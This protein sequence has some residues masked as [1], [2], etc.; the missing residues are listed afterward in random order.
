MHKRIYTLIVLLLCL[1]ATAGA[2]D[3]RLTAGF[4]VQGR[5]GK[6]GVPAVYPTSYAV[7]KTVTKARSVME[8]LQK[9]VDAD[10]YPGGPN[11]DE[12][13]LKDNVR[14]RN[15]K[16]NGT[17]SVR[18]Y[19]GQSVLVYVNEQAFAV[20][21]IK[22]GKTEYAE[23]VEFKM[24]G[25]H[26]LDNV[27]VEG[28]RKHD[29]IPFDTD[30]ADDD[31]VNMS[32]HISFELPEG[33]TGKNT[34]VMVQPVA[35]DCQTEDTADYVTPLVYEGVRYHRLQSR[36]MDFGYSVNEPEGIARGF[37]P[38]RPLR[39]G[40][41]F[42]VDTTLIYRKKDI[43]RDY[44]ICCDILVEDYTHRYMHLSTAGSCNKRKMFKFLSLDGVAA[45]L[46]LEEYRIEAEETMRA[47]P[48]DLKL[49]FVVGKAEL[50]ADSLNDV[51]LGMLVKEMKDYGDQLMRVEIEAYASPDGGYEKNLSLARERGRAA[52]NLVMRGLGKADVTKGLRT[53]VRTWEDV[54]GELS[55]AGKKEF[56]DSVRAIIGT[57][58]RQPDA[59]LRK[60]SFYAT[61]IEPVL[62]NMRSMRCIYKYEQ[63]HIMDSEE[64]LSYY[65]AN[66]DKLLA[67]DKS[68]RL[69]D[70]DYWNLFS[71][72]KDSAEQDTVTVLAYRHM[73]SQPDWQ[74]LKFSQYAANRMAMLQLRNG[75]PDTEILMPFVDMTSS[76]V[77]EAYT[78]NNREAREKVQKN[79]R[80]ILINHILAYYQLEKRD[81][82]SR[83]LKFWFPESADRE[84]VALRNYAGFKKNFLKYY[85]G[86][87]SPEEAEEYR[88]TEE[89]VLGARPGNRAVLYTEGR[90]FMDKSDAECRRL[91]MEMD[92]SDARK[93]Y[94]LA[95]LEADREAERNV[96]DKDYV[97][98]YLALFYKSFT[99]D[100]GLRLTY[101][102]EGQVS[103]SLRE[104]YKYRKRDI[105]RYRELLDDFLGKKTDGGDEE[106]LSGNDLDEDTDL[107]ETNV[108]KYNILSE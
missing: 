26:T 82:A 58:T 22:E 107:P 99:I 37:V 53:E 71:C 73:T 4:Q 33:L 25:M 96:T 70:G 65:Y 66:K 103:D 11:Y 54:A 24:D 63:M 47:V 61:D 44:K 20:F 52:M 10:G 16:A 94:L 1:A 90:R 67:G 43:D 6:K 40:V 62:E 92:D 38:G 48:R 91:V 76:R 72:V 8:R 78:G 14:F 49:N 108:E 34:R 32:V 102:T 86:K 95:I 81:S 17:F 12:A 23:T 75:H 105:P 41:P 89:Y 101:F 39:D 18:A 106:E 97:P 7:F 46:P 5:Y 84:V 77:T 15:A 56:A 85:G 50:T 68:V 93:W 13:L 42:R 2:Q 98:L 21:E 3:E 79:R 88:R 104:K 31:G 35:V 57:G 36:H 80:Q 59:M 87:L 29:R 69:S 45:G 74:K 9:A 55:K 64:L 19:P 28:N 100:P 30:D 27:N 60:L 83:L 51:R